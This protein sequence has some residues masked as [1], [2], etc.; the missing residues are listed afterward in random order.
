MLSKRKPKKLTKNLTATLQAV[1]DPL[2]NQLGYKNSNRPSKPNLL[3]AT[4]PS[5][6]IAPTRLR[7]TVSSQLS[8]S[9]NKLHIAST[10]L[11]I[12]QYFPSSKNTLNTLNGCGLCLDTNL[13]SMGITMGEGK[14][15]DYK[16]FSLRMGSSLSNKVGM[17]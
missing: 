13:L 5:K 17:L 6:L 9:R 1:N 3:D 8:R 10:I 15:R 7:R 11:G 14:R 4:K 12:F 16:G 2:E